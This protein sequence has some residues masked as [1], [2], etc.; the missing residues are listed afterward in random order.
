MILLADT[1][2]LIDL[3]HVGGLGVLSRIAPTEV[4]D[5]VLGEC[6]EAKN[7]GIHEQIAAAGIRTVEARMEWW[8]KARP[9]KNSKLS[10]VDTLNLYYAVNFQRLLLT[11]EYPLRKKCKQLNVTAHGTLWVV[12]RA[13]GLRLVP[14]Q[15]L[16]TWLD[17]LPAKGSR[18]R[19]QDLHQLKQDI[20]CG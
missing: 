1:N 15:D 17:I 19:S 7:P 13:Y 5:V 11:N 3:W 12:R 8:D 20:R 14:A 2:V 16:C 10:E 4:L 18:F 9:L 6:E